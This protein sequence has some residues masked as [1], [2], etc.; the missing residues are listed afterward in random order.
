MFL[1][2]LGG[3]FARFHFWAD[4]FSFQ[5][6]PCNPRLAAEAKTLVSFDRVTSL[7]SVLIFPNTPI[8]PSSLDPKI[9]A[10]EL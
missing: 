7:T 5:N 9:V 8:P 4:A 1:F 6:S 3:I 10:E 2:L